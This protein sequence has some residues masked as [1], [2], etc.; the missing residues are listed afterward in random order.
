MS[1]AVLTE[2][3]LTFVFQ[4]GMQLIQDKLASR[5]WQ[6]SVSVVCST[7]YA[8]TVDRVVEP[9]EAGETGYNCQ[10]LRH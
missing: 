1:H 9:L 4:K 8:S 3:P 7:V 10:R 2:C 6:A 5:P